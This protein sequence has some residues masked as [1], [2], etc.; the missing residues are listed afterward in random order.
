MTSENRYSIDFTL[1]V[2]EKNEARKLIKE[3]EINEYI[4]QYDSFN[5]IKNGV[6]SIF[7]CS[8]T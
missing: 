2:L 4:K 3:R 6:N 1:S 5:F 7:I 8:I